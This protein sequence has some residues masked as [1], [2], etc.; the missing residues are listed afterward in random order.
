MDELV[1]NLKC[2]RFK[3]RADPWRTKAQPT[4][5]RFGRATPIFGR[6]RP[7]TTGYENKNAQ[8]PL[9]AHVN[10]H[11]I[12]FLFSSFKNHLLKF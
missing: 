12:S 6:A 8:K 3:K 5:P 7:K 9:T 10:K 2:N 1:Q 11:A 4:R